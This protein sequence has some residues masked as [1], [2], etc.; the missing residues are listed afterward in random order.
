[1]P[2]FSSV[3]VL[4]FLFGETSKKA[5]RTELVVVITPRVIASDQD[6]RGVAEDFRNKVKGLKFK[7]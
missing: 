3:P 7:F 1:V 5:D 4:G 2:G 6:A